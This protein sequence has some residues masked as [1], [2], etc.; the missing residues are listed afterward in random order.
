[1]VPIDD[2]LPRIR[3]YASGCDD[4]TL[5]NAIRDAAIEFCRRTLAIE[6]TVT[7]AV[8]IDE[9]TP[10]QI[11]LSEDM[12]PYHLMSAKWDGL[13]MRIKTT[14][15]MDAE[16]PDW[17]RYGSSSPRIIVTPASR[18]GEIRLFEKPSKAGTLTTVYAMRPSRTA[19]DLSD[20]LFELWAEA[21]DAG[22]LEKILRIPGRNWTDMAGSAGYKQFFKDEISRARVEVM[23]R[24]GR[25]DSQVQLFAFGSR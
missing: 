25:S 14:D 7:T 19:T 22:A 24:M 15:D 17:E 20:E 12:E 10:T 6:E 3:M 13:P 5:T 9:A 2:F 23:D 4:F 8:A 18:P 11:F 21:L 1:M 16:I